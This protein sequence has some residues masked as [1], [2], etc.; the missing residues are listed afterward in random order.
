[1]PVLA[2]QM[3]GI[4]PELKAQQAFVTR[5]I[6]EEELAFLKDAGNRPAPAG[7]AGRNAPRQRRRNRRQ[8]G[9]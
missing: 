4:F 2:D 8:H 7:C 6:E 3:A 9:F 1:M 5:V